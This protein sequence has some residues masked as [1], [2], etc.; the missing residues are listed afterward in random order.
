MSRVLDD[1]LTSEILAAVRRTIATVAA[2]R[3]FHGRSTD[4]LDPEASEDLAR[5]IAQGIG[6]VV[7]G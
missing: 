6:Y 4:M 2:A 1:E 5:N 7:G 3:K